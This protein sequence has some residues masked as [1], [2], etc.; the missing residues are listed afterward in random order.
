MRADSIMIEDLN[1]QIYPHNIEKDPPFPYIRILLHGANNIISTYSKLWEN[2][3][4]KNNII[5]FLQDVE[6]KF[7]IRKR[8]FMPHL[9]DLCDHGLLNWKKDEDRIEI[10]MLG[11]S[12]DPENVE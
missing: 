2:K 7:N 1:Q 9:I 8:D 11:W 5:T 10:E 12:N 3:D 4:E 6:H